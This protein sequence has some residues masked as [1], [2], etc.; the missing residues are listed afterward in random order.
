MEMRWILLGKKHVGQSFKG[1][2]VSFWEGAYQIEGFS[3]PCEIRK[4]HP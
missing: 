3:R 4:T 1:F 2:L